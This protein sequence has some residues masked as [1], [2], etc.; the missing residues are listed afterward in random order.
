MERFLRLK[1]ISMLDKHIMKFENC[2]EIIYS[3]F[4]ETK[5]GVR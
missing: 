2:L 5:I 4:A 1:M 3:G